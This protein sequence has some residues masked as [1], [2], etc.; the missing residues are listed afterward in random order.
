MRQLHNNEILALYGPAAKNYGQIF[1]IPP[2]LILAVIKQE[3][4]GDA[5]AIGTTPDWGL[6]QITKPAL[7]DC[8]MISD[9]HVE[10][11]DIY[12]SV[13]SNIREG[14][15]YLRRCADILKTT[16]WRKVAQ[17]YNA[18]VGNV[19]KGST[20]GSDYAENVI[21][22]MAIFQTLLN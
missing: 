6:M 13:D 22:F 4:G 21:N 20:L 17:A 15:R 7:D 14:T 5:T 8:N 3:T 1:D 11:A 9:E 18:G 2:E 16:E 12:F 19:K 10:I